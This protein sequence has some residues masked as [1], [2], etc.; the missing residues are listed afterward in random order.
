MPPQDELED[1]GDDG[2]GAA[3]DE[4]SEDERELP[5]AAGLEDDLLEPSDARLVV[6]PMPNEVAELLDKRAVV[7]TDGGAGAART[8]GATVPLAR[9]AVS[10]WVRSHPAGCAIS[11]IDPLQREG[12]PRMATHVEEFKTKEA[13]EEWLRQ[14]GD[15]V[16]IINVAT[17]AKKWS[18]AT[19]FFTNAKTYTVTYE[20]SHG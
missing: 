17:T 6:V 10:G 16:K 8:H 20:D 13:Y 1:G 4:R 18:L 11:A 3:A 15:T 12:G 9:E 2:A 14:K 7:G 19:G 5:G